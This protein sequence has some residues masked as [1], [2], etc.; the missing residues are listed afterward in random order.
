MQL[1]KKNEKMYTEVIEQEYRLA[2]RLIKSQRNSSLSLE[3]LFEDINYNTSQQLK[4][5]G[6]WY[7]F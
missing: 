7:I 3:E 5:Y 2:N 1:K 6:K 4:Q